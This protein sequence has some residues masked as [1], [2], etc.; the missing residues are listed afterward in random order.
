MTSPLLVLFPGPLEPSLFRK[1][2]PEPISRRVLPTHPCP[3]LRIWHWTLW[4]IWDWLVWRMNGEESTL[5]LAHMD[6]QTSPHTLSD[7]V[8]YPLCLCVTLLS[9]TWLWVCGLPSRCSILF[10]WWKCLLLCQCYAKALWH[11]FQ[12]VWTIPLG[13]SLLLRIIWLSGVFWAF[14]WIL[15]YFFK[16]CE[17]LRCNFDGDCIESCDVS[18]GKRSFSHNE[19]YL[20]SW[21]GGLPTFY[22]PHPLTCG[23]ASLHG[24]LVWLLRFIPGHLLCR[25]QWM[26][27]FLWSLSWPACL[28]CAGGHWLGMLIL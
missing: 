22:L 14:I 15:N 2:S 28:W 18:V 27:L 19:S 3:T 16:F 21:R 4:C 10:H 9:I 24:F 11:N 6:I 26:R 13:L 1:S 8:F 17:G 12:S 5:V 23:K 20:S 25:R 7:A